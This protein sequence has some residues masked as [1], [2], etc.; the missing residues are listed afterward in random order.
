MHINVS[1]VLELSSAKWFL[2]KSL[3]ITHF[4]KECYLFEG[5]FSYQREDANGNL[6]IFWILYTYLTFCLGLWGEES[7]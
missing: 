6:S 2:I 4:H 7:V 3:I 5:Y 1:A